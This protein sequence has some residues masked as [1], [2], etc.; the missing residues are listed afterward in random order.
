MISTRF[1]RY[2]FLAVLTVLCF[3]YELLLQAQAERPTHVKNVLLVHGAWADGSSW[4]KVIPLLESEGLNVIAV[5]LPLTS[6]ADD[7]ATV[8]RAIALENGPVLLVGHS[9]GGVV[10]TEAG[11][12]PKV[13]GLV[14]VAA[15]APDQGESAMS[16]NNANPTP[17][18][19]EIRVDSFGFLKLTATGIAEDF[20][21]DLSEIEKKVLAATQG[22]WAAAAFGAPVGTPAWR[23]KPTWFAIAQNDRVISPKLEEAEAQA[24]HAITIALPTSHVA[25]LAEPRRVADFIEEA[26]E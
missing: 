14:F 21:Q 4:A 16:L 25:M 11:N 2:T 19:A 23:V 26:A 10:I 1:W 22:P 24:M 6:L 7:A 13:V 3:S 5:Q 17:V 20:A 12:D 8:R 9:Y 15:Y 18:G